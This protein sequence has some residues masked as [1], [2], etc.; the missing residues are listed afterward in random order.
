MNNTP[1]FGRKKELAALNAIL[2]RKIANLVVVKGRR[3]IGKSRLIEEFA[4]GHRFYQ[5]TGL[6]P[7][8]S[9]TAQSQRNIF[10]KQ[11]SLQTGLPEVMAD[12]WNKLFLLLADKIKQGRIII[13]FDEISWMGSEDPDFLGKLKTAWDI[14]FKKNMQLTF[15][16][17]GSISTWIDKN[18]ISSTGFLGRP[19]LY[20][21]L[22]ELPLSDCTLF[23]ESSFK[24]V[25]AYEKLKVLAV[26]GGI[27]RYLELIDPHL[28]AEE[29]IRRL[30]FLP[31]GPLV[32]EFEF[33][34]S[35]LFSKKNEMYKKIISTLVE[36]PL[37]ANTLSQRV[38]LTR[39]GHFSEYLQHLVTSG[40]VSRDYIWHL[41]TGAISKLCRFRIKDNYVRFYL[42]YI[43][44]NK[45]RIEKG[46]YSDINFFS[47][48]GLEGILGLQF[49]NLV[50]N[51]HMKLIQALSLHPADVVFANPFFQRHTN[52][53]MGCQVDYLVQSRFNCIYICEIKFSRQP[54]GVEVISE[55]EQKIQHLKMPK[56]FSY[57][58]VLIHVNGVSDV[59]RERRFFSD[60]IDF[61]S[62]LI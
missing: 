53:Q 4:K 29:N 39:T 18:I 10:T 49:E 8:P 32:N 7:T 42:K 22:E 16:L 6:P 37:D 48:S 35:D 31:D 20:L 34:F 3:R 23:W 57:R 51:N 46:L 14:H 11:L 26:T 17:C 19:T 27:P 2:N 47:L 61:S 40:F 54:L 13:L 33:I 30:C 59:V 58:P 43:A 12:D 24:G 21:T 9:T 41:K 5:F 52:K 1:F 25:S 62:F 44:P 56:Y 60:I 50:F 55:V 38:G 36:G 45:A 15:V 28:N